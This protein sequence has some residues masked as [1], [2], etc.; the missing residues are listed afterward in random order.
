MVIYQL[1]AAV[2]IPRVLAGHLVTSVRSFGGQTLVHPLSPPWE[3]DGLLLLTSKNPAFD[4]SHEF[5]GSK[6][7]LT[8]E[9]AESQEN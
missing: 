5:I 7:V 1:I 6:K 9:I 8:I 3:F 2:P 4:S